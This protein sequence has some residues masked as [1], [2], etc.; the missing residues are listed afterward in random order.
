MPA[1][2][3]V[4]RVAGPVVEAKGMSQAVMYELVE[5]G[6]KGLIGEIIRL[7]GAQATIQVYQ[8]TTSLKLNEPVLG[9]GSPLSVELAPGLVGTVFDGI[10]RP[11]E[12]LRGLTGAFIKGVH[13]VTPLSRD[14]KWPFKPTAKVG[15]KLAGGDIL[16]TVAE[17]ALVEHRVLVPPNIQGKLVDIAPQGDYTITETIAT[18]E[19]SGTKIEVPMLQK[20]P[21]RRPRPHSRRLPPS[22]PL[23]TGQ[24]II[25]TFFPIAKGGSA[26]IP[27]GFGTGKT[28]TQQQLAK[29][30][31]ANIIIY[32]GCGERG[33]E[34]VD[35]L[36]SFPE[37]IDPTTGHPLMERT[38]LVANTS[39][40]PVS[41]REASIYTGITIAEYYRD[42]GYTVALMADSTSRW[43]EALREVSG[44]LEEMPAEEGFPSYLPSRLAEFYERTGVVETLGSDRRLGSICA[45]GAVSPPGGD[46]SEPVTQH[47]KRFTRVFWALDAELADARHYPAINWMQSYSGYISELAGWW[48]DKVDKEWNSYREEAMRIL[49]A[50]D[51]L[52]NIVKLVGP[53]ALPDK[54]R[55]I[56]ET[57]R[58]IRIALL[59]QNA[60]DP[61]DTY[62]SPQKQFKMLKIIVNFHRY[63]DR[64]VSRGAPIFKVTQLPMMNEIMR[65]KMTV[66]N[67]KVSVLDDLEKK[68]QQHFEELEA[69]LR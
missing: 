32:V 55:L 21:V 64:V 45:I 37:L 40:M 34:M 14:K 43:A 1:K 2:G 20:W 53:E 68:M 66:T 42:M 19:A 61:I 35:V 57:A 15:T 52:K 30:S 22:V 47:T 10:Q 38:I 58:I 41:A 51:D 7:E 3:S 9:T 5:V 39:N 67:D 59:Q 33:N 48:H 56:L 28:V 4:I 60:L 65:M 63:A 27:G 44:R 62:S 69:S 31:D 25:D 17:T 13:G 24:R 11:L 16:G 29:W 50:E 46:F 23:I 8:N 26:S 54:Q 12:V 49:Q 6:N 18:L 36:T